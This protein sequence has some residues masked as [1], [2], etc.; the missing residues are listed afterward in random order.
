MPILPRLDLREINSFGI[1]LLSYPWAA[2]VIRGS[3]L[4]DMDKMGTIAADENHNC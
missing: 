1:L 4:A 2:A 3:V